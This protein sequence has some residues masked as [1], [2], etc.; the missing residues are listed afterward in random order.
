MLER[1]SKQPG[2]V[3]RDEECNPTGLHSFFKPP[4]QQS[5]YQLFTTS[6]EKNTYRR[7]PRE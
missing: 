1:R 6:E 4:Y 2:A 5:R 3:L 7:L